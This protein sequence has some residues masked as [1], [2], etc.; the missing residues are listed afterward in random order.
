MRYVCF[1]DNE[2]SAIDSSLDCLV[3]NPLT[4]IVDVIL[5]LDWDWSEPIVSVGPCSCEEST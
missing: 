1:I 3:C 5:P 2:H 4:F